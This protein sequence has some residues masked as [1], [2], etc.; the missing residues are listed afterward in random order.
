MTIRTWLIVAVAVSAGCSRDAGSR[1]ANSPMQRVALQGEAHS[2]DALPI[3]PAASPSDSIGI[4]IGSA[5]LWLDKARIADVTRQLGPT[6]APMPRHDG[7]EANCYM[8]PAAHP[9]WVSV[10]GR[11][12]SGSAI[13]MV[14][15]GS[16]APKKLFQRCSALPPETRV[17]NTLGLELG[18]SR[19]DMERRLGKGHSFSKRIPFLVYYLRSTEG[20]DASP[21]KVVSVWVRYAGDKAVDFTI[22]RVDERANVCC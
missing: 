6:A 19:A 17:S 20:P 11:P 12:D 13:L 18:M 22:R 1:A 9:T 5:T 8:V 4:R 3:L 7:I 14:H 10:A 2:S 16:T 15:I 21:L